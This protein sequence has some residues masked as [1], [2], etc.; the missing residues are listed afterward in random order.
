MEL[1]KSLLAG[2]LTV[3]FIAIA[4]EVFS[5]VVVYLVGG[6]LVINLIEVLIYSS[7]AALSVGGVAGVGLWVMWLFRMRGN[8]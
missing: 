2:L 1:I 8:R 3:F 5:A 7:K 4:T 6:V